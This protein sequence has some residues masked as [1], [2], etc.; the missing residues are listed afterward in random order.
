MLLIDALVATTLEAG[1]LPASGW[2]PEA[3]AMRRSER[4][5]E[6]S[7]S[8]G[9]GVPQALVG[10]WRAIRGLATADLPARPCRKAAT[11]LHA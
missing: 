8:R 4:N 11:G 5:H 6:E 2:A 10:A 9:G 1:R 7:R 3:P